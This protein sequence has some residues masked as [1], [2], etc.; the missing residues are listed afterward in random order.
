MTTDNTQELDKILDRFGNGVIEAY[1]IA[2]KS[3]ATAD[4]SLESD[5]NIALEAILDWHNKQIEEVLDRLEAA[6]YEYG[7]NNVM[8]IGTPN[9]AVSLLAIE[10]ERKRL[11]GEKPC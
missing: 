9:T 4:L 6:A 11:K 3:R 2:P 8:N 10:A 1:L 5:L 7:G